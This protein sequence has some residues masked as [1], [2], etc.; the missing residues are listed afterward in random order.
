LKV[1]SSKKL[2]EKSKAKLIEEVYSKF[3]DWID[4]IKDLFPEFTE[5]GTKHCESII[6]IIEDVIIKDLEN[7]EWYEDRL[8]L[9]NDFLTEEEVTLLLLGVI[10][11]DIGM[12][13]KLNKEARDIL[14]KL[15]KVTDDEEREKLRIRLN[16]LKDEIRERHNEISAHFVRTNEELNDILR[17]YGFESYKEFLAFIV[18]AHREDPIDIFKGY[19][20]EVF[21]KCNVREPLIAFLLQLAD[22]MDIGYWR[23]D[24]ERLRGIIQFLKGKNVEHII[25]NKSVKRIKRDAIY[26]IEIPSIDEIGEESYK[27]ILELLLR[28]YEKINV[29]IDR[30]KIYGRDVLGGWKD[31]IPEV[32]FDVYYRVS[33]EIANVLG[34][35]FEVDE[36]I[37]TD[38]LSE[39]VYGGE[40]TYAFRELILNSFDAIKRRAY[41]EEFDPKV[42]VEVDFNGEWMEIT[43][44]DN[45][46]D[47]NWTDVEDY[48]L[49][50]GK[51]F[52]EE[53]RKREPEIAKA[54]SP[55]GYYGIGFLSTFMLLK[56]GGRVELET[57]RRGY[58]PVKILIV[59]PNLPMVRMK[60]D[61]EDVGTRVKILCRRKDVREFFEKVVEGS[62]TG[63]DVIYE[64]FNI[65]NSIFNI[66]GKPLEIRIDLSVAGRK[67]W[68]QSIKPDMFIDGEKLTEVEVVDDGETYRFE[69]WKGV[70]VGYKKIISVNGL[71]CDLESLLDIF[72][73]CNVDDREL[74]FVLTV[75]SPLPNFTDLK[76]KE[77]VIRD[78]VVGKI[79]KELSKLDI[80]FDFLGYYVYKYQ[81]FVKIGA[82]DFVRK[83][84]RFEDVYGNWKILEE[85][86]K[87]RS[88]LVV[89]AFTERYF[90]K[91]RDLFDKRSYH[92]LSSTYYEFFDIEKTTLRFF[93]ECN[94]CEDCIFEFPFVKAYK[95]I[96]SL[97]WYWKEILVTL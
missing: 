57:K 9:G 55:A 48:L 93:E 61:R 89:D 54:I 27:S 35:R 42:K 94:E 60:S 38:L 70:K 69:I 8:I 5:H 50:V 14:D 20:P 22:D 26:Y 92:A 67:I 6:K 47:M 36:R 12:S 10:L 31:K 65:V 46:I 83:R 80:Y 91:F 88:I 34:G 40:W 16:E 15:N 44:E 95:K 86:E 84:L 18:E 66:K 43:V 13:P 11:H 33:R 39:K 7:A 77:I 62:Y 85:I 74:S 63:K 53:L 78:E 23:V 19:D 58:D 96:L 28:W 25:L 49:K 79:F 51:S 45:G 75:E 29:R 21:E 2:K 52:Y 87:D 64:K 41:E 68:N 72:T 90:D 76:K 97:R 32:K 1:N 81:D 17:E 37:F 3:E 71:S 30:A 56:D 4:A 24:E 82:E 73:G 59:D